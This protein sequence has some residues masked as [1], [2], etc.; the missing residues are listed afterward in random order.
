MGDAAAG[1][2]VG[3]LAT[4]LAVVVLVATGAIDSSNTADLS[5]AWVALLQVPLWVGLLG[6]PL[7]AS[8]TKGDGVVE[9]FGLRA[10]WSD[11]PL[12]LVAG[13]VTQVI[14]IPIL[15]IPLFHLFD[16]DQDKVSEVA[17]DLTDKAHG[18]TGVVLLVL[19]VVIGAPIVE[20]LFFRGL[21]LRSIENRF[22]TTWAVIG[23]GV[24][25]GLVHFE[26]IQ[27]PALVLFGL[28]LGY[29]AVRTGRLG[30]GIVAH[31]A[32]NAWTVVA[33]LR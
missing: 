21:V 20:E 3:N 15:Y 10:T 1:L 13:L 19:I 28:V 22:G 6:V 24:V 2:V 26:A 9:D 32:F 12:G 7:W 11:V 5:I 33:L 16:I 23:S 29:L 30:A 8:R 17:R 27:L 25:F 18:T 31:M 14:L 4:A